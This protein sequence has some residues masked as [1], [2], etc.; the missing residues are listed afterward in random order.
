[1]WIRRFLRSIGLFVAFC[2]LISL[3]PIYQN[4]IREEIPLP[5][6]SQKIANDIRGHNPS[7]YFTVPFFDF[8]ASLEV[9]NYF[10]KKLDQKSWKGVGASAS[11]EPDIKVDSLY[12]TDADSLMKALTHIKAGQQIIIEP[13]IY[14]LDK[15]VWLNTPGSE[16]LPNRITGRSLHDVQIKLVGEGLVIN[17]P[18]WQVENITFIG[19][20]QKH[21][22]CEHALHIV[23]SGSDVVIKNNVFRDFN[24]AIKVNGVNKSYPDRG[25]IENNTLYNLS[26][27]QTKNPVTPIDIV[28]ANDWRV[29]GNFI[30]D[31]QKSA[32][33]GVSYAAFMKGNSSGG[34]FERNLVMCEANLKGDGR[35]ALGLSFGG[36]GTGKSYFRDG[37]SKIES[38]NGVIRNNI[39]MH[40]PNDVGIYLNKS[41][42]TLIQNNIVYNTLGVDVRYIESSATI[43]N[44][45]IGGRV[46]KRD[47][48]E[49]EEKTN[50]IKQRSLL[51]GEEQLSH[52][53]KRADL[54]DFSLTQDV[55]AMAGQNSKTYEY[56]DFCGVTPQNPYIGA[57]SNSSLC[58][59]N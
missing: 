48:A 1:M 25:V 18:F 31:I 29:S 30:S 34:I 9:K 54:G 12:I 44:N 5:L 27:R 7:L 56:K 26:P 47:G 16:K 38:K 53:F 13:G 49:F 2:F 10:F 46:R 21:D 17:A 8:I 37:D 33:D 43:S 24:A 22:D 6:Y 50:I 35:I 36:G 57:V 55:S 45:F 14:D 58:S 39:I 4:V 11:Y 51:T 40:C 15:S 19:K 42:D 20:C 52:F 32:G 59:W 28:A 3:I 23:G 41:A